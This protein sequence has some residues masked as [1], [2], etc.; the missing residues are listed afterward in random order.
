M[1]VAYMQR[2]KNNGQGWIEWTYDQY[3]ETTQKELPGMGRN[4]QKGSYAG[5]HKG[6]QNEA[7][8]ASVAKG[9]V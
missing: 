9:K 3:Q 7:L 5:I 2:P 6:Q 4:K 8:V 1:L